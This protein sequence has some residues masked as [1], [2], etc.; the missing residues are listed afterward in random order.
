M[1]E[2][3]FQAP[4]PFLRWAGGKRRL[5]EALIQSFPSSFSSAK[6]FY[7]E[8]FVGGGALMLAL[9]NRNLP[10]YL[11]GQRLYIN[12]S[13][14][15]LIIT[16]QVI[17]DDV[18]SLIR[19]L[20][21]IGNDTS[22]VA[23]LRVRADQPRNEVSRAARFIYLNKTCFNGLWR[24]N[25]KGDFNVPWGKL[26]NPKIFDVENLLTVNLRLQQSSI[27]HGPYQSALESS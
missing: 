4:Q 26:K 11:P 9:G 19:K 16:Y 15:D 27:T 7:Y 3:V 25:S 14:P 10:H 24:V 20:E 21:Q 17:R 12:D 8:P 18:D 6:N 5:V 1:T 13:N 22:K 23:Y 2:K